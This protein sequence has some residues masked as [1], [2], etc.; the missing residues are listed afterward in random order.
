MTRRRSGLKATR[1][2]ASPGTFRSKVRPSLIRAS[3]AHPGRR[4][5]NG[6]GALPERLEGERVR[7]A[8]ADGELV[9]GPEPARDRAVAGVADETVVAGEHRRR[10][11]LRPRV[12]D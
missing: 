10:P 9:L 4:T 7:H 5:R 11:L 2:S 8:R 3:A 12:C 6:P 1:A